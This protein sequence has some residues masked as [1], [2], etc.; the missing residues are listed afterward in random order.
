MRELIYKASG[1]DGCLTNAMR[2]Q[3]DRA[4]CENTA[5]GKIVDWIGTGPEEG[6]AR[7][8]MG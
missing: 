1:S 8:G 6:S 5:P 7:R 3:K 2:L 4:L